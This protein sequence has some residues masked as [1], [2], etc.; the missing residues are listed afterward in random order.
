MEYDEYREDL[1]ESR[2]EGKQ[3]AIFIILELLTD[4]DYLNA[5]I[6]DDDFE[7]EDYTA[8]LNLIKALKINQRKKKK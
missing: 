7:S 4:D 6:R 2:E 3:E 5:E 8:L 1:F